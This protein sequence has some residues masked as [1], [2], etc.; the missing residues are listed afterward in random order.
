MGVV[1]ITTVHQG[2]WS[3]PTMIPAPLSVALALVVWADVAVSP[4]KGD[5]SHSS[6]QRS[7]AGLDRPSERTVDTLKRFA[8][9]A[10]YRRDPASVLTTLQ[11]Q[12]RANPE[13]DLVYALAELSW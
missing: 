11:Q 7:I 6:I 9:D 5:K 8:H 1:G 10:R 4:S 2:R 12:A 13:P 3:D